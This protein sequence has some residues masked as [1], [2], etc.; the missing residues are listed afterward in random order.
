MSDAKLQLPAYAKINLLLRVLGRRDDGYH[1]IETVFQTV[2]LHDTLAYEPLEDRRIEL[3]CSDPDI[4]A[5]ET[6][7]VHRAA[8]ALRD[9]C[10][11]EAGARV[12]LEKRIPSQAGLGGGSSDAAA[13][14]CGLASLWN[15]SVGKAELVRLAARLGADVPF[16][17]TGGTALG[18]GL[19]TDV[20][21]LVDAPARALVVVTP[22]VKVS[23]A[24]AY[25]LLNAPAL[26]KEGADVN[27]PISRAG[28]DFSG[29]LRA[30][31]RNDF[32]ASVFGLEPEIERA[33]DAL[34]SSGA[35]AAMLSGSGS[36]VFGVFENPGAAH[37]AARALAAER[38]WQ[39]F[40]CRT[41]GRAEYAE[42]RR[43]CAARLRGRDGGEDEIGA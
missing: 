34:R 26:T 29:S 14:L 13:T 28:L 33:R 7:L 27:L 23:T 36:S 41:V 25:K 18:T 21:P 10:G 19:G 5:D 6:N 17:L 42:S 1:E 11:V 37:A 9:S 8:V 32:E 16:F 15:L 4:P 35:E 31:M 40:E 20:R 22:G 30:V 2:S 38:G 12:T 43:A 24:E 3:T 39:V